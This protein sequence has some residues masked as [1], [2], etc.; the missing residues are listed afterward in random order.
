MCSDIKVSST[1]PP[2]ATEEDQVVITL[3]KLKHNV[4]FDMLGYMNNKGQSTAANYFW[5]WAG[6]MYVKSKLLIGMQDRE[7]VYDNIP[8]VFKFNFPML[9][10]IIDCF[11]IFVEW[12]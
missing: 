10:S 4:S 3:L 7:Y 1:R 6:T 12:P 2:R 11:E 5:K 9:T 8:S